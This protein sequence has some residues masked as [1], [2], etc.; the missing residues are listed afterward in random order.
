MSQR[1][2]S[3]LNPYHFIGAPAHGPGRLPL[4]DYVLRPPPHLTHDRYA[5]KTYSGRIICRLTSLTPFFVGDRRTREGSDDHAA[6]VAPFELEGEPALPASSLRG[7]LSSLAEAASNSALRVLS[8]RSLSFRKDARDGLSAVGMVVER[9]DGGGAPRLELL[10]LALPTIKAGPDG[11]R[12]FLEPKYRKTF[13]AL[14][15]ALKVYVGS[16]GEIRDPAFGAKFQ[17]FQRDAP[18]FYGLKLHPRSWVNTSR[19]LALDSDPH[20]HRKEIRPRQ[21]KPFA[22]L[23][24]QTSTDGAAPIPWDRIPRE[25]RSGYTRGIC[26][27]LGCWGARD[28]A[29]TKRHELFLPFPEGREKGATFPIP[30]PVVESFY[31]MADERTA[32]TEERS[33][34]PLPYEPKGTPRNRFRDPDDRRFRLKDGDLVYFE[35][36]EDGSEVAEISLSGI[37]RARPRSEPHG[38]E[39]ASVHDFF[40][41]VD[42][43]L[44]PFHEGRSTLTPAELLFGFVTRGKRELPETPAALAGRVRVSFGRLGPGQADP[45]LPAE[46]LRVLA[47][48]KPPSPDL[49]FKVRTGGK[50]ADTYLPR[51]AHIPKKELNAEKHGPQ[52]RKVYLH[53][54]WEK[55]SSPWATAPGH[56][57]ELLK[58]KTR[59]TPLRDDLSFWFHLDFNNL[60]EDELALLAYAL[61]PAEAFRPK[62][63]MGKPLGLGTVRIDPMALLLVDR[64][65]RYTTEGYFGSRYHQASAAS[66]EDSPRWPDHYAAERQA[67]KNA[68]GAPDLGALAARYRATM[69]PDV[70]SAIELLGETT[71]PSSPVS[72][73]L[74]E[75]GDPE[76]E[77]FQWFMAND[78]QGLA[79]LTRSSREIPAL[80]EIPPKRR[81]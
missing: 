72:T 62:L 39:P 77:T 10:P 28:V 34:D 2:R 45:Y 9:R 23:L 47:S 63:G 60:T 24:A 74:V 12:G 37:W 56:A 71:S 80:R 46:T 33:G 49:Y 7:L 44:L 27:V 73:P 25:K 50:A 18:R 6:E 54:A 11:G 61:R 36:S 42:P 78:S 64:S 41:A 21:G 4:S 58:M 38:G 1:S 79:P 22:F 67:A 40:A 8:D 15:P 75:G 29:D 35:P 68:S 30:E 53:H 3:Y 76:R 16:A 51:G 17:T 57:A 43:E 69:N 14:S 48:P 65:K 32:A 52:G 20:Q 55:G 81:R 59:I 70:R 66:R 13:G 5:P 26:R 19:D 31:R